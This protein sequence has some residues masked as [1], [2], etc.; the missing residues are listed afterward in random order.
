MRGFICAISEHLRISGQF[1]DI[2]NPNL[3][4]YLKGFLFC[5]I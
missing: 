5:I 3:C 2:K 1:A 4:A